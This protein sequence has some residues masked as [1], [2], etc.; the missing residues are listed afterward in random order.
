MAHFAKLDDNNKVL[1][2]VVVSDS[3]APTEAAGQSYL[4]NIFGWDA[5]KWKQTSYNTH[6][7]IHYVEDENGQTASANQGKA[8]RANFA[9]IGYTYDPAND[10]FHKD[11]PHASW[12]LNTT[13]GLWEPPV[14]YPDD[15]NGANYD[16][17]ESTQAWEEARAHDQA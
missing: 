7:G 16:W 2:V 8:L 3:D 9:A 14:A 1:T 15:W 11:Q 5:N 13:S 12:T 4:Q 17:N 6:G 10:I